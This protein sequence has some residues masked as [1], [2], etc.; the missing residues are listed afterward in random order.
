MIFGLPGQSLESWL[1]SLSVA[2]SMHPEHL[3][4]YALTIEHG[5]PFRHWLE[6]GL[7]EQPDDD[8]AADM[9]EAA[10]AKL[11]EGGYRQYE[12]SN[13]GLV[14]DGELLSCRHNLQY[15]RGLPYL[16]F[17]AGAHGYADGYR[18]ANIRGILPF[19]RRCGEPDDAPFPAGPA[20]EQLRKIDLWTAVQEHMMVGLR[21]V[22]EGVSASMFRERFGYDI[23]EVFPTQ[24]EK[25]IRQGL[26]EWDVE[27]GDI[28]RLSPRG[29]LL[30][31][32]VFRE[33]IDL[34]RPKALA[35]SDYITTTRVP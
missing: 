2:L 28:L 34:P 31:N 20:V 16:G 15:W 19:I 13:W 32:A 12:I 8:L 25:L 4:L 33:F 6:K 30:G 11:D 10:G 18:T 9:Y 35:A 23:N 5:T 14:R 27:T 7:V 21:L 3:S 1:S 17:G 24:I 26:L 29:H 22:N